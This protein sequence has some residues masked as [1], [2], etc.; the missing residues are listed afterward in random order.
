MYSIRYLIL[1]RIELLIICSNRDAV[2]GIKVCIRCRGPSNGV[3]D[4]HIHFHETG[5]HNSDGLRTAN[6][7]RNDSVDR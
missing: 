2:N 7:D 5:V 6:D 3:I 4:F 1:R